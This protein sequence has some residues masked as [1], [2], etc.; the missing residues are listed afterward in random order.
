MIA[1]FFKREDSL[2][3][4]SDDVI[5]IAYKPEQNEKQRMTSVCHFFKI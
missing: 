5:N 2:W 3:G 4:D 1:P